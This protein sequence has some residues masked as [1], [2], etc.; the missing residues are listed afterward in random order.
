MMTS[1]ASSSTTSAENEL[2]AGFF[3][4]FR[5]YLVDK[6]AIELA[7]TKAYLVESRLAPVVRQFGFDGFQGLH[8][9]LV[10]GGDPALER[11]VVD[12]MTTNETSFFRDGH[13]FETLG[14]HILPRLLERR[15]AHESITVWC[16]ACS[17]GQEPYSLAMLATDRFPE[18]VQRRG[19]R[20][21]ATDLSPTMVR[22]CHEARFS[23]FEVNRG[24][25][26]KSLVTHFDQDGRY[27]QAKE[28]LRSMV[29]CEELNLMD[30]WQGVPR[31]DIVMIRNVL[32]YFS[33]E[34]KAQILRRI[35]NEVL[36]PDGFLLLGSSESTRNIDDGYEPINLGDSIVF[37]PQGAAL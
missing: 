29:H 11:A 19:L 9:A 23:Q 28:H 10:A 18:L 14:E 32:I 30:A 36:K 31:A 26:A 5:S 21:H 34:V 25:P 20:I 35:R 15:L 37:V 16:A 2:P 1:S 3:D 8:R 24:L 33:P 17:S 6:S 12:A 22:R 4:F 7:D 13:P 27:W